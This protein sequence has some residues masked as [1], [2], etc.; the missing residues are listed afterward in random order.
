[1]GSGIKFKSGPPTE[2]ISDPGDQDHH[3]DRLLRSYQTVRSLSKRIS[4]PLSPEDQTAQSMPDASPIKWHLAHTT[5][6]FET[7]LLIPYLSG[8]EEMDPVYGHLFNSYY[9]TVGT[10]HARPR[11]GLLTR[12]SCDQVVAYRARTDEAME[13]LLKEGR[14]EDW[15]DIA[16]RLEI[17][18][19]HEQQHQEL[20]LTDL[21]HLLSCNPALPAAY[22]RKPVNVGVGPRLAWHEMD[23]GIHQIGADTEGFAFDHEHPRHDVLMRPFALS[24]RPVTNGDFLAFVQDGGYGDVRLWLSEAWA[25]VQKDGWRHPLYWQEEDG[26][27]S[28]FILAGKVSLDLERP[29]THLS[30]YEASAYAQWAAAQWPGARLPNEAELERAAEM[31]PVPGRLLEDGAVKDPQAH[32]LFAPE[33]EPARGDGLGQVIGDIWE[34][35]QSPYTAYPGFKPLAGSLGEYNGKFMCGQMVLRG[36][37]CATPASH[38][39]PSYRN[40]FPPDA[41]WQ[42]SG[43]RL[44]R[45]LPA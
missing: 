31:A 23:G 4:S 19:H 36:G 13:R 35:T 34:W 14:E 32:A 30:F 18:L 20:M 41:R 33:P 2:W 16:M 7:F 27:W 26:R 5:W 29:V 40:F 11:R 8:Y 3:R 1:M 25:R 9:H 38:I 42:F 37:S 17:G 44:A 10:M 43:L 39:R 45:D 22:K 28:E 24:S 15:P 12:P 21:K 6:F